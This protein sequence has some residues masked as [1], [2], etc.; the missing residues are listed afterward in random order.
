MTSPDPK[1]N[2]VYVQ[3]IWAMCYVCTVCMHVHVHMYCMYAGTGRLNNTTDGGTYVRTYLCHV[4]CC[5]YTRT[6][7]LRMFVLTFD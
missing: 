6:C 4:R 5:M 2:Q 7:L 1:F 3:V